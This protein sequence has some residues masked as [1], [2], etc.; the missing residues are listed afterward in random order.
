M[1]FSLNQILEIANDI[2]RQVFN[3]ENSITISNY[4]NSIHQLQAYTEQI[5]SI[6]H[7]I[8]TIHR[9]CLDKMKKHVN[10]IK[11]DEKNINIIGTHEWKK[12]AI[13]CTTGR[14]DNELKIEN[15][16]SCP[17]VYVNTNIN[18]A[19]NINTEAKV[20][21]NS[22]MIPNTRLYWVDDTKQFAIRINDVLII[23]NLGN[24]F[25]KNEVLY[26][27]VCCRDGS[28]CTDDKC[29]YLHSSETRNYTNFSWV[30][31]PHLIT[32]KNKYIRHIGDRRTLN[33]DIERMKKRDKESV[34]EELNILLS[35]Y[36]HDLLILMALKSNGIIQN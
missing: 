1:D 15:H 3:E 26:N 21:K 23:G 10:K 7:R 17:S 35:Q 4:I 33:H 24:I 14:N 8:E 25:I 30:Y 13:K 11:I 29:K 16:Y 9:V 18:I 22:D 27:V 6:V 34:N 31:S 12:N 5:K 32:K 28:K 19:P 20:V 2:H 36:M